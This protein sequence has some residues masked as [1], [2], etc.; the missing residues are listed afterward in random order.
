MGL[1]DWFRRL[2]GIGKKE[3]A[4]DDDWRVDTAELELAKESHKKT[5]KALA[6]QRVSIDSTLDE[7]RAISKALPTTEN[8]E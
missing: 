8:G 2:F 3:E 1:G 5:M 7:L 6:R 4:D